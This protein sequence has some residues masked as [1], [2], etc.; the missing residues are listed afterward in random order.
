MGVGT[1]N[2]IPN[3]SMDDKQYA[4]NLNL[5]PDVPV[6]EKMLDVLNQKSR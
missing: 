5:S 2:L 3:N 6:L 4:V 1:I